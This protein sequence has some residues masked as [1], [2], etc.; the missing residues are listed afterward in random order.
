MKQS[1]IEKGKTDAGVSPEHMGKGTDVSG[2]PVKQGRNRKENH[3]KNRL[4][5]K[6]T[7]LTLIFCIC[8]ATTSIAAALPTP[9]DDGQ[10]EE[11]EEKVEEAQKQEREIR[12]KLET[13]HSDIYDMSLRIIDK[14]QKINRTQEKIDRYNLE[15]EQMQEAVDRQKEGIRLRMRVIYE[16]MSRQGA[17]L[18]AIEG[19]TLAQYLNR[20][21]YIRLFLQYD[22]EKLKQYEASLETLEAEGE[23]LA[24]ASAQLEAERQSLDNEYAKLLAG[25]AD[26]EK[27][28]DKAKNKTK[29]A[30]RALQDLMNQMVEY[31][32]ALQVQE[33]GGNPIQ[34]TAASAENRIWVDAGNS[35]DSSDAAR[36]KYE[37]DN[38]QPLCLE[39]QLAKQ[40]EAEGYSGRTVTPREGEENLLAHIIYCESG[41]ES[42]ESKVAVG[43]VVLNR[44]NSPHFPD[45]ITEVI[46]A[47]MQFQPVRSGRLAIAL[48]NDLA[49]EDCRRAAHEV[50]NN[51]VSGNWLFFRVHDGTR[52]GLII[53][54]Q[55]FY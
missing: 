18:S 11:A 20:Q 32:L 13:M 34:D 3:M 40:Y 24:E 37:Y 38:G 35:F 15:L 46:Y 53:D 8:L 2:I 26:K 45:T 16:K 4:H 48:E 39:E 12:Q 33:N 7:G 50:L 27:Q 49:T 21:E 31:E 55:I 44:V 23:K 28:L 22:R 10:Q 9:V 19:E 30:K 5:K 52:H 29:K 14:Q 1:M 54:N 42:Y 47:P 41:S 6:L 25:L 17:L 43:S 51:G 36:V